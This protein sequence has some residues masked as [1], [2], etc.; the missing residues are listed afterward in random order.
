MRSAILR[1]ADAKELT[2]ARARRSRAPSPTRYPIA[3]QTICSTAFFWG[4]RAGDTGDA[5]RGQRARP[6]EA[7]PPPPAAPH[8]SRPRSRSRIQPS[9]PL[10]SRTRTQS[11]SFSVM[12]TRNPA[13]TPNT[14]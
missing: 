6:S 8:H 7:A 3:V 5:R 10:A 4:T 11:C 9:S 12:R 14:D 1:P 2:N 13:W